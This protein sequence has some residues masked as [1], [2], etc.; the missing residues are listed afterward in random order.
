MR[1]LLFVVMC[2]AFIVSCRKEED[3]EAPGVAITAPAAG[4]Q[5]NVLDVVNVGVNITD[6]EELSRVDLRL[7]SNDMIPVLPVSSRNISGTSQ[8]VTITYVL[9]DIRLETG[10]YYFEVIAY[11]ATG[12]EEHAF[13]QV[14]VT[15]LPLQLKS[16]I[17]AYT[18]PGTID[19]MQIDSAWNLSSLGAFTGDFT[20]LAVSSWW[21][22]VGYT[23]KISGPFRSWSLDGNYSGWTTNAFP[24]TGDYWGKCEAIGR[25]W[26]INFRADGVIRSKTWTGQN[27]A[28]YTA[29]SGYFFNAFTVSGSYFFAD[30]V[31][32]TGTNRVLSVF[33][34]ATGGGAVQ[35]TTLTAVPLKMFP[36][37]NSSIYIAAN[38]GNQAKLLIYD[39]SMNG[40]WEPVSLP[41]GRLLS[42]TQVDSNTLLLAM[43]NG[44]IYKFTYNPVGAVVWATRSAQQVRYDP[45]GNTVIT[46]EG[47]NV[48]QYDY[49]NAAQINSIAMPDSVD[50][51]ELRYNR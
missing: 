30:Q 10:S 38:N 5:L 40:T 48:R 51:V 50:D 21:Q 16:I 17:A 36:R 8:S 26:F 34:K 18:A 4:S 19:V 43:D 47:V 22:Q 49:N 7:V 35:Q 23:G 32:A 25:D 12:N 2:V 9:D 29:N 14:N 15:A 13:V 20:D 33:D 45:A 28:Q 37:D 39:F 11:D 24:S 31:D 42:A 27:T 44:N 6:N 46:A 41:A 3:R 1:K